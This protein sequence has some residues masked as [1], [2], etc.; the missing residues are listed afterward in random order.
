MPVQVCTRGEDGDI[1]CT[2]VSEG[3]YSVLVIN[4]VMPKVNKVHNVVVLHFRQSLEYLD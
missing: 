1:V 4:T 2:R 3:A